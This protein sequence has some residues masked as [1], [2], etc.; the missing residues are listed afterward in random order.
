[1]AR[2]RPKKFDNVT[3]MQRKIDAYVESRDK[4]DLGYTITAVSY[5][6]LI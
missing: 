4:A 5:T 2:G 6:H 3:E 1:M